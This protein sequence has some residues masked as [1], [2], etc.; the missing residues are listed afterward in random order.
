MLFLCTDENFDK[1]ISKCISTF[2]FE[3]IYYSLIDKFIVMVNSKNGNFY[4][5][6][7]RLIKTH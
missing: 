3:K 6:D 2:T 7:L 4:I 5:F 1:M